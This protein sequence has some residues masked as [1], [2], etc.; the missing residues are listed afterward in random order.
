MK[1][2]FYFLG[3]LALLV[4]VFFKKGRTRQIIMYL[5][6]SAI[7]LDIILMPDFIPDFIEGFKN[8]ISYWAE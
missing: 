3:M 1:G 5:G 7:A 6:I 4:S 8:G 2:F